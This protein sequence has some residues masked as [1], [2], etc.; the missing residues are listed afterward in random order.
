MRPIFPLVWALCT[1]AGVLGFWMLSGCTTARY[2]AEPPARFQKPA[3]FIVMTTPYVEE[4][5][6]TQGWHLPANY[7]YRACTKNGVVTIPNPCTW[8]PGDSYAELLCHEAAHA[9]GWPADHP[10]KPW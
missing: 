10:G 7:L 5:C 6:Q 1:L 2:A 3:T 8:A 9:Q 4:A